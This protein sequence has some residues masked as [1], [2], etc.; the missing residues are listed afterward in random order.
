MATDFSD[1]LSE[2]LAAGSEVAVGGSDVLEISLDS[3]SA[4]R[5]D[6][7]VTQGLLDTASLD[8]EVTSA[9][10]SCLAGSLRSVALSLGVLPMVGRWSR[11]LEMHERSLRT[12]TNRR[13]IFQRLKVIETEEDVTFQASENKASPIQPP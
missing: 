2:S 12:R 6:V 1:A 4:L 5:T 11:Q 3:E 10:L 13:V 8:S 7:S 9:G